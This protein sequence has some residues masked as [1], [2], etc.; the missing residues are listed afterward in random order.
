[1]QE[2]RTVNQNIDFQQAHLEIHHY[3][4]MVKEAQDIAEKY[5]KLVFTAD[6]L[7]EAKKARGELLEIV[8]TIEEQRKSIK[9]MIN[10][11]YA[12]QEPK[13][14]KLVDILN[15]PL[16]SIRNGIKEVDRKEKEKRQAI[17]NDYISRKLPDGL[18]IEQPNRWLNKGSF[19]SKDEIKGDVKDE[20]DYFIKQA[21]QEEEKRQEAYKMVE[22]V[23]KANDLDPYPWLQQLAY[24]N[25]TEI[26]IEMSEYA[27]K[28]EPVELKK[29]EK[30]KIERDAIR[31]VVDEH[32]GE[33]VRL[34]VEGSEKDINKVI[35]Y[36][37]NLGLF[38]KK[39]EAIE[40]DFDLPW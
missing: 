22:A 9:R 4:A 31:E 29:E 27:N 17:I 14:K 8:N 37:T 35:N 3:D 16:N 13:I 28:Q 26:T 40:D 20:I 34:I 19:T 11:P 2:L 21:I 1:M 18:K 38:V 33:D 36:A 6:N 23:A 24:K 7:P 39:E 12:E 25:A 5:Q 32:L 10:A 30:E 15:E